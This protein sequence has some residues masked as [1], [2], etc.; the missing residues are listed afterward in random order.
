MAIVCQFAD[1]P[2]YNADWELVC[3]CVGWHEV[4]R[5]RRFLL[6]WN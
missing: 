5:E 2:K 6:Q 1:T 3:V 4:I